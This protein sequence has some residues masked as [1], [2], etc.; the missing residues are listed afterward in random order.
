VGGGDRNS[1][2]SVSYDFP[3][4]TEQGM[5]HSSTSREIFVDE[6]CFFFVD[7]LPEEWQIL[8]DNLVSARIYHEILKN[9]AERQTCFRFLAGVIT[10]HPPLI[11]KPG[12]GTIFYP[13]KL[14]H[15][16]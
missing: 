3:A 7:F 5:L 2:E 16:C 8:H 6:K 14:Q 13:Y 4:E 12:W 9:F 15:S 1:T 11:G 10:P